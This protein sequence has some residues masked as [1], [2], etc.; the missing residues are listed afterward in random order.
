MIQ[1]RN[2][3][4]GMVGANPGGSRG[5]QRP[6]PLRRGRDAHGVARGEGV[7]RGAETQ[8]GRLATR[9]CWRTRPSMRWCWRRRTRCTR[10]RR[11]P[12]RRSASTSSA[13]SPSPCT[14]PMP[15]RRSR[16]RTKAG[17]TLGLG[18]NRRF[19]PEMTKLRQQI[20]SGRAR[21]APALRSDDD[22]PECAVGAETGARGL[23]HLQMGCLRE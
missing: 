13:R 8:A 20:Q 21:D 4:D 16:R 7:Q 10:R 5:R 19:H 3:R 23:D 12:R 17:V 2:R 1:S 18:Y 11:S 6:D 15:K 9:R 14:K 22:L